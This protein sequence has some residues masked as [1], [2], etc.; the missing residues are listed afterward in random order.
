MTLSIGIS[1]CVI[2]QTEEQKKEIERQYYESLNKFDPNRE[3]SSLHSKIASLNNN[4]YGTVYVYDDAI[5]CYKGGKWGTGKAGWWVSAKDK[6]FRELTEAEFKH[7]QWIYEGEN[8][9]TYDVLLDDGVTRSRQ[10]YG[11]GFSFTGSYK[12]QELSESNL[13]LD[14]TWT[15]SVNRKEHIKFLF[16]KGKLISRTILEDDI[17]VYK[18]DNGN[19]QGTG[20]CYWTISHLR[21]SSNGLWYIP[22][23]EFV[24]PEGFNR[25][26]HWKHYYESGSLKSEGGYNYKNNKPIGQWTGYFENG[27]IKDVKTWNDEGK[28]HGPFKTYYTDGSLLTLGNYANGDWFG[29]TKTYYSSGELKY[30]SNW[31]ADGTGTRKHYLYEWDQLSY[32]EEG[33]ANKAGKKTGI[34][35]RK[36]LDGNLL[37]TM[38][39]DDDQRIRYIDSY[40]LNGSNTLKNGTGI[41]KHFLNKQLIFSCEYDNG[42]RNGKAVWYYPNGQLQREVVYKHNLSTIG[43]ADIGL[44]WEVISCYAENGTKLNAGT[45]KNGNGTWNDYD[46]TGKLTGVTTYVNGIKESYTKVE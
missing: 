37:A 7:L 22:A 5:G 14:G 10:Y 35:T 25:T 8:A 20:P 12:S 28:L 36:S 42:Q 40:D 13:V 46:K 4:K 44:R 34:W 15:F 3:I 31:L 16:E 41:Y 2:A 39:Y 32:T 11:S 43:K 33:K 27:K 1:G 24:F 30:E 45:L 18:F 19:V 21:E 26:G 38:E 6:K 17:A 9:N 29:P 23:G